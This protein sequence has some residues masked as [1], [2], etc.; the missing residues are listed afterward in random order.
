VESR[1]RV[2]RAERGWTVRRLAEESG[3]DKNTVSEL[4]RGVRNPNPLTMHKL[5]RALNVE[6]ADLFPKA[7]TQSWSDASTERNERWSQVLKEWLQEHNAQRILMS[8]EEVVENLKRL[9]SGSDR[10]AIVNRFEQEARKTFEEEKTVEDALTNEFSRGG[11]LLPV[12]T[13]GPGQKQQFFARHKD[14]SRLQREVRSCYGRY[15]RAL[16]TVNRSLFHAGR[17]NDFVILNKRPQTVEA[18]REATRALQEE[19]HE[20]A[21]GA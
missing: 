21:R 18:I 4:E 13:E 17:A 11:R 1:I 9:A 20:N 14:Y 15:Y 8:D 5:A 2:T 16:E 12:P 6:V 19:A 10:Q 7:K 3:V